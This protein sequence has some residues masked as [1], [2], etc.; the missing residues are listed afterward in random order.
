MIRRSILL[1]F[2]D[3]YAVRQRLT[4]RSPDYY[5][6]VIAIATTEK[7]RM[8]R[9]YATVNDSDAASPERLPA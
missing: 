8:L 3:A 7:R 4:Q 5:H 2:A 1:R 9:W 6:T